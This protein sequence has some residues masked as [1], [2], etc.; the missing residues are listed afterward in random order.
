[1]I[2]DAIY[3]DLISYLSL[4]LNFVY[5]FKSEWGSNA[6]TFCKDY[7]V[8]MQMFAILNGNYSQ[9]IWVNN[10]PFTAN[11]VSHIINEKLSSQI[12]V[13]IFTML[14]LS[15][16]YIN[17]KDENRYSSAHITMPETLDSNWRPKGNN[18]ITSIENVFPECRVAVVCNYHTRSSQSPYLRHI[19]SKCRVAVVCRNL[20]WYL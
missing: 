1:M 13:K 4:K 17:L 20:K 14:R 5:I 10:S 2:I 18:S 19:D 15:C 11:L 16:Y 7:K 8:Y 3:D 12:S 6:I 9:H